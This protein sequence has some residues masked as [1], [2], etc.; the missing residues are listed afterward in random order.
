MTDRYAIVDSIKIIEKRFNV[1]V[2]FQ[3]EGNYNLHPG[4]LAPVITCDSPYQV[5]LMRFGITPAGAKKEMNIINARAEG[6]HNKEDDPY[7]R[8]AKGIIVKPEF[9]KLIRSQ[10][11]LVIASAFITG[12]KDLGLKKPYLVYL[13]NKNRP[14]AMAG[15]YDTWENTEGEK[16][17]GF[18]II[19]T[20]ANELLLKIGCTRMPVILKPDDEKAW[21]KKDTPLNRITNL[22]MPYP[23]GLMNAYPIAP[24]IEDVKNNA[25][26]YI[27][28]RGQRVQ[29]EYDFKIENRIEH[30]GIEPHGKRR[31]KGDDDG[32]WGER[33]EKL[34]KPD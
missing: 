24:A 5:Q 14:F 33:M 31:K 16:I 3:L 2:G 22:L 23:A 4:Q 27:L 30:H 21:L 20:I 6:D 7:Y 15:I 13:Q 34:N 29:P 28:P 10:R 26:E 18:A 1:K 8:G 11:C 19:T 32:S 9:R 12:S 25:K 17:N